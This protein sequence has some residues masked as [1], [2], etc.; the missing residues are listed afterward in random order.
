[1]ADSLITLFRICLFR[2][3]PQDLP[4]SVH[5]L[6][7]AVAAGAALGYIAGQNLTPTINVGGQV[8]ATAGFTAL[9]IYALLALRR[10]QVR[11]MQTACA[12]FGAE[13][14]IGIPVTALS[15]QVAHHGPETAGGA[16]LALFAAWLWHLGVFGHI[17][18]HALDLSLVGGI[19]LAIVYNFLSFQVVYLVR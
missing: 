11:F 8:A 16:V 7:A 9:F 14:V 6:G 4:Y 3:G 5:L 19:L 10:L 13:A 17:F 15:F 2:A 18:R 12:L 1:M